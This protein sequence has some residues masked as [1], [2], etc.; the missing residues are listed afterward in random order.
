MGAAVGRGLQSAVMEQVEAVAGTVHP[1]NADTLM[2]IRDGFKLE[3]TGDQ[4]LAT[5]N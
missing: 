4:H 3:D 5:L 2:E 1:V